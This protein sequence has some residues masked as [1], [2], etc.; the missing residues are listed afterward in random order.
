MVPVLRY[1]P[2]TAGVGHL[3]ATKYGRDAFLYNCDWQLTFMVIS[4]RP[5]IDIALV[6]HI[7]AGSKDR[8]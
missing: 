1:E 3:R 8:P 6:I 5:Y 2:N 4:A 7:L